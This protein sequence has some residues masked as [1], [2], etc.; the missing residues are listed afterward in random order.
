VYEIGVAACN[1]LLARINGEQ[2]RPVH[3]RLRTTFV[4]RES[5]AAPPG[6]MRHVS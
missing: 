5:V 6:S 1:L 3:Q 2:K 4:D